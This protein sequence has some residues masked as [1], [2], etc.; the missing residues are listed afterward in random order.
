M[1]EDCQVLPFWAGFPSTEPIEVL[2]DTDCPACNL[3]LLAESPLRRAVAC[4]HCGFSFMAIERQAKYP[5]LTMVQAARAKALA[6]R[7][8]S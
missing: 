1:G 5:Q 3:G 7:T 6:R 2:Y 4:N 8:Q